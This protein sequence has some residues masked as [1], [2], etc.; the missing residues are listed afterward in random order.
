MLMSITEKE[1]DRGIK[2]KGDEFSLETEH[3]I[4][5]CW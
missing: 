1:L 5:T 3:E 4:F 2:N